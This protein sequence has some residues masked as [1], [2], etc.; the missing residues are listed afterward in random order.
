MKFLIPTE[1]DDIHAVLVKL[2]LEKM[3]H[4]VRL[5]FTADL[6]TKQKNSVYIDNVNYHWK[7]SDKYEVV[8]DN[9]YDVVWWRR[10]RKPFLPKAIAHPDDYKFVMRENSLFFESLM[11]NLAPDAWWVNSKESAMKA[12]SKLLQLKVATQC[13]MTIP[14]TLCSNDP[15]DI[16]YFLLKHENEGVIYK[17]LC[18]GFWFEDRHLKMSYTSKISFLDLPNNKLLQ[19]SPGIFQKE[20]KKK[21]ELRV[22]CFGEYIVAAKINSQQ[23]KDGKTDWRAITDGTLNIEPYKLPE[24]L[25]NKIRDFMER[26]GLVFGCLDFVVNTDDEYIFLEVNEQGQFLWIEDYNP[27][28]KMLDIFVNFLINKSVKFKWE[29]K[30]S[31]HSVLDFHEEI[32]SI[33]MQN[34]LRHVELNSAKAQNQ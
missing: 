16:R 20:I 2:A 4:Q 3:G 7:S 15:K 18:P 12:N 10:A 23:H 1:P 5:L 13:G 29:P 34:M 33:I 17:T 11:N 9:D 6:P 30:K 25:E 32:N 24:D 14:V 27:G 31:T 28:F 19:L 8:F 21:Y 22:T 26:M